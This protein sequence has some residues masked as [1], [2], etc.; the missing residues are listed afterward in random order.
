MLFCAIKHLLFN[1]C[2]VCIRPKFGKL[3]SNIHNTPTV[4]HLTGYH[5]DI[6]KAKSVLLK[7]LL[8]DF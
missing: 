3:W 5:A 4:S 6:T 1:V 2:Y 7:D 8:F